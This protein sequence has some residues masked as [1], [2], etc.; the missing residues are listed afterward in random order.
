GPSRVVLETIYTRFGVEYTMVDTTDIEKVKTAFRPNTKLLFTE[1][2]ANPTMGISDLPALAELA[3]SHNVPLVVDNTFC[4]PY[5]QN[6]LDL[7]ADIV[8]HSMTKFINGH[9]DI[10]AGMIV[11]KKEEDYKK[12]RGIMTNLG[13]NMDPHQAFMTRRGLKTLAIRIDR[14]QENAMVIAGYLEKHPKVA[15][16]KYPGLKSHPQYELGKRQMKGPGAM[17]SFELKGGLTAGKVL[18]DNVKVMLLAVSLG[19]IETLIQHPASMTH[20]KVSA[21]N[22]HHAGITDG[23]VRL[24]VGIEKVDDLLADLDQAL[25]KII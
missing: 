5:L 10:V 16:V 24:S 21:E 17:I 23:L 14:A 25:G 12:L 4:S 2:P 22:R 6:P 8:L 18:M 3:H 19:G 13:C 11:A 20:S 1:T 9:A 7:G 15:W